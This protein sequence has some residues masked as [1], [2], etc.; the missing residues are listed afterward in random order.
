MRSVDLAVYADTLAAEAAALH[1]RLERERRRL[2]HA[3]LEHEARRSLPAETVRAL[4]RLG[5]LGQPLDD[6]GAEEIGEACAA[7]A[8]VQQL[9]AWV[10]AELAACRQRAARR[11]PE[12]EMADRRAIDQGESAR[13]AED[14]E[15]VGQRVEVPI[16]LVE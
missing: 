1:S 7:L 13:S 2:R 8:A 12:R 14:R 3:A 5:I 9:Q 4:E 16:G 10:E 11:R 6:A 15:R